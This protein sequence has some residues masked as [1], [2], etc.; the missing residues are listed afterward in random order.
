LFVVVSAAADAVL[1]SPNTNKKVSLQFI[2]LHL[3]LLLLLLL[4]VII[5]FVERLA[6]A[7]SEQRDHK[8][9]TSGKQSQHLV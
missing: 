9:Q 1:A 6:A 5:A 7:V 8:R 3:L 4:V 2:L